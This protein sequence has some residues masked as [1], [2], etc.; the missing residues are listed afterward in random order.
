MRSECVA[1]GEWMRGMKTG[2]HYNEWTV[3]VKAVSWEEEGK[4]E[5][6]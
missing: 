3:S 5:Q 1:Q 2:P 4:Q 6:E